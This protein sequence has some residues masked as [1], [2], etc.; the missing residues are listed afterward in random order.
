M[1]VYANATLLRKEIAI[2]RR[3]KTNWVEIREHATERL[4]VVHNLHR[5]RLR[6]TT[7]AWERKKKNPESRPQEKLKGILVALFKKKTKKK[8]WDVN[9]SRHLFIHT[10]SSKTRADFLTAEQSC[11]RLM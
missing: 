8:K 3:A 7:R 10:K 9:C 11:D 5:H 4:K 1:D 2:Q 6:R